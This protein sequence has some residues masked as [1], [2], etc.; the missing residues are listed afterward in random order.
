MLLVRADRPS[1]MT[2][3]TDDMGTVH[4]THFRKY[5][6]KK[7]HFTQHYGFHT[8]GDMFYDPDWNSLPYFVS[9]AKMAFSLSFLDRFEAELL[10]GQVSFNQKSAIYNYYNNYEQVK[11]KTSV[12]NSSS[13]DDGDQTEQR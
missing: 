7:C 11:K 13:D 2:I 6:S 9:T 12:E 4:G 3:Y 8:E 10:L 1:F 5:C